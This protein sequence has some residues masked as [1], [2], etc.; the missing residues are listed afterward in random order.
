MQVEGRPTATCAKPECTAP[1]AMPRKLPAVP[2]FGTTT[3]MRRPRAS[4][5]RPAFRASG[6][7][8]SRPRS[9]IDDAC[10]AR[11]EPLARRGMPR[12]VR[13]GPPA[14]LERLSSSKARARVTARARPAQEAPNRPLPTK[15]PACPRAR[16]LP[17]RA[18]S[19]L[20]HRRAT[21]C[22]YPAMPGIFAQEG[23][24]SPCPAQ[25]ACGMT[26]ETRRQAVFRKPP[27]L[28]D[29]SSLRRGHPLRI[30]S[31]PRVRA[32]SSA[33]KKTPR[34]ARFGANAKPA[35]T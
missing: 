26:M 11:A 31:A 22:V 27:A 16:V 33:R 2:D 12:R 25:V 17:G 4:R 35:P 18:R 28:R 23:Q 9:P 32:A 29:S 6:S 21:P 3:K 5:R 15:A 14:R 8:A 34:S 7:R 30:G 19:S 20:R 10:R 1:A 13:S 24:R